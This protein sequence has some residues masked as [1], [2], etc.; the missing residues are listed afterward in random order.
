MY[1]L[2]A[3]F[4]EC[5]SILGSHFGSSFSQVMLFARNIDIEFNLKIPQLFNGPFMIK[6]FLL[7]YFEFIT[8]FYKK[9]PVLWSALLHSRLYNKYF[10]KFSKI[11]FGMMH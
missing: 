8:S 6:I 5:D 7:Y 1:S 11:N 9:V 10:T 2:C 4:I 3:I